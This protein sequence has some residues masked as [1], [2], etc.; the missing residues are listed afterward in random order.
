MPVLYIVLAVPIF[1]VIRGQIPANAL[2]C[3]KTTVPGLE[4]VV[5]IVKE[6]FVAECTKG[7]LV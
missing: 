1:R 3:K 2:K 4:T 7:S 6:P 5:E